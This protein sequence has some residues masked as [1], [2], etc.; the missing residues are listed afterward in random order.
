V[1]SGFVPVAARVLVDPTVAGSER[2]WYSSTVRTVPHASDPL[3]RRMTLDEWERL[4]ED[5]DGELVDGWLVEEEVPDFLHELVVAW[6]LQALVPWARARGGVAGGSGAKFAVATNRGRKPDVTV[7]LPAGKLPPA[8]GLVRVPPTIAVEIV[9]RRPRDQRR[10]RVDKAAEYAAF[11]I[12]WYWLVDPEPLRLEI[13]RL[14]EGG[15]YEVAF[16]ATA[17]VQRD[18]PGCAGLVLDLDELLADIARLPR[19]GDEDEQR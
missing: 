14:G 4:P 5:E 13:H 18:V 17:G 10:D 2:R 12:P 1:A 19:D 6:L 15:A 3:L 8:R 16:A 7:F 11:G 9:S